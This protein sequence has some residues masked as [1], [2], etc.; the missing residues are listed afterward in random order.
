MKL[1]WGLLLSLAPEIVRGI[2]SIVRE[3]IAQKKAEAEARK[4]EAERKDVN[5][6][7]H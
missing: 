7:I 2:F 4:A 6:D 3:R 1:P 5:K